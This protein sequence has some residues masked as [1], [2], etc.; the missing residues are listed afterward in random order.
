MTGIEILKNIYQENTAY[1]KYINAKNRHCTKKTINI[2]LDSLELWEKY[3]SFAIAYCYGSSCEEVDINLDRA[4]H[5]YK[6]NFEDSGHIAAGFE[7]AKIYT[8]Q[9]QYQKA[10]K[11]YTK[12]ATINHHQALTAL[13]FFYKNGLYVK[14]DLNK[15]LKY[16]QKGYK[17]G[18]LAAPVGIAIIY[19]KQHKY[20]KSLLLIIK[21]I[22]LR[23]ISL[24][25]GTLDEDTR[26]I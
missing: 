5:W 25:K 2:L 23:V 20:I 4:I 22:G 11:I 18:N 24:F 21:V 1:P 15:A 7:L 9:K 13:G 10:F 16:Y 14:K 26:M 8:Y 12:L 6:I 3:D 17:Y 19:R